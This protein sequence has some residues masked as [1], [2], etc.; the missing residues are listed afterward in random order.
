[1]IWNGKAVNRSSKRNPGSQTVWFEKS[2]PAGQRKS[3]SN[4]RVYRIYIRQ[5]LATIERRALL[6]SARRYP[7][8]SFFGLNPGAVKTNIRSNWLGANSLK[9]RFFEFVMGLVAKSAETY[10]ERLVPL[11][12]SPSTQINAIVP[13]GTA[14]RTETKIVVDVAGASSNEALLGVVPG[15]PA[16]F[17]TQA[18]NHYLPVAAALN[19][20]GSINSPTNRA[21][22]GSIVSVFGTGFGTLVPRPPDG[23][24][25]S[26]QLPVLQQ[27]ID[28]F[29]PGFVTVLYAGPAPS[30]VAG[31]MQVNFRLPD[32]MTQTPTIILFAGG[33]S[34]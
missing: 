2:L 13:F 18:S 22:P 4:N 5:D 31:V 14:D 3:I 17:V 16:V 34:V 9:H 8:A 25:L 32:D 12:V 21:A 27:S 19:E 26:G 30:Q 24:L 6:D 7:N 28:V 33:G 1:M 15:V 10:A 11:L 20:D 23:S 29:G